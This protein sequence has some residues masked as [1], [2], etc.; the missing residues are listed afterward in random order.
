MVGHS[1]PSAGSQTKLE[2]LF[3][4]EDH[5]PIQGE[6]EGLKKWTD[7]NLMELSTSKCQ[8]PHMGKNNPRH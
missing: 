4:P 2:E 7:R 1:I 8:V 6:L 3:I 5:A